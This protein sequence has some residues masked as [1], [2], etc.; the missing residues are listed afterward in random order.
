MTTFKGYDADVMSMIEEPSLHDKSPFVSHELEFIDDMNKN[1]NYKSS[2]GMV[3]FETE[4]SSVDGK[5]DDHKNDYLM[6]P[7]VF[8][9]FAFIS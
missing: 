5:W 7:L 2:N 8:F 6:L 3:N 4:I 9:L 1:S